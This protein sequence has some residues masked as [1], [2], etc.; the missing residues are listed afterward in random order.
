MYY[1]EIFKN[2]YYRVIVEN[3]KFEKID[4]EWCF[5]VCVIINNV[6]VDG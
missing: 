1:G 4:K 5:I 2:E 6:C 3:V